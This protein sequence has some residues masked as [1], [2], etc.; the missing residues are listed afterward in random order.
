MESLG[1]AGRGSALEGG[2]RD[3]RERLPEEVAER[4]EGLDVLPI[5]ARLAK[6]QEV[7]PLAKAARDRRL[8]L[9]FTDG[10]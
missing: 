10:E 9:L 5:V 7:L 8:P 3:C 1:S 6:A 2:A 4:N